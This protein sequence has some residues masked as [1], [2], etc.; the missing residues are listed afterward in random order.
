MNPSINSAVLSLRER[1]NRTAD[2]GTKL[3]LHLYMA[4]GIE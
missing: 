3:V 1:R 4:I 2:F